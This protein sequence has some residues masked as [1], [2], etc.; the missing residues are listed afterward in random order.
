LV[1]YVEVPLA[2]ISQVIVFGAPL[3][4]LAVLGSVLVV[5]SATGAST[6]M[7]RSKAVDAQATRFERLP[8]L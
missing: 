7:R 2:Y 8:S 5:A 6:E 3:R 4:L 1:G